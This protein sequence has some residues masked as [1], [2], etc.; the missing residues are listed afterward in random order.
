M[1]VWTVAVKP[2][3]YRAFNRAHYYGT[4]INFNRHQ[5]SRWPWLLQLPTNQQQKI[6]AGY[7]Y[8]RYNKFTVCV[9]CVF[10]FNTLLKVN[11]IAII[12]SFN[13]YP[14]SSPEFEV[15]RPPPSSNIWLI[16]GSFHNYFTNFAISLQ[17]NQLTTR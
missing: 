4:Q 11:D 7:Y 15:Q 2:R 17:L 9:L 5:I 6:T 8:N 14:P 10:Q 13:N 12:C 16:R 3:F 1:V